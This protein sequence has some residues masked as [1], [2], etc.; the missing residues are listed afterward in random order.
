M[1]NFTEYS[2]AYSVGGTAIDIH[3]SIKNKSIVLAKKQI[4]MRSKTSLVTN[5]GEQRLDFGEWLPFAATQYRIS[6]NI[7]DYIFVPVFL[8]P[9]E[10]PN[11][12]G[13]AFP[14][15]TLL[16][17]NVE[18][19]KLAYKTLIG[20]PVHYEHDN[21]IHDKAYGIIVDVFLRKLSGYGS[22]KVWKI[23]ALVAVD[24]LKYPDIA[25]RLLTN[26]LNSFSMGSWVDH[27][28]CSYCNK[29]AGRCDHIPD[30][31]PVCFY[32]LGGR[33]VFKNMVGAVFFETSIVATPAWP[34]AL[35]DNLLEW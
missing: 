4:I 35:N 25:Q 12:N 28:T 34:Q 18:H 6:P 2:E 19:G 23:M 16:E 8:I 20:K 5:K 14:I 22:N 11:R 24:R 29:I 17:F 33:L 30:P 32:E 10:I 13:V 26:E 21:E 15:K 1:K 9:S 3:N 31:K 27:Y 7:E